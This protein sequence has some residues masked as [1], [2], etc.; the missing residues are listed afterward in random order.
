MKRTATIII[1]LLVLVSSAACGRKTADTSAAPAPIPAAA[2]SAPETEAVRSE[3]WKTLS[4]YFDSA[5]FTDIAGDWDWRGGP[6]YTQTPGP[7]KVR[8]ISLCLGM[9]YA[10]ADKAMNGALERGGMRWVDFDGEPFTCVF[11]TDPDGGS[12]ACDGLRI[13]FRLEKPREMSEDTVFASLESTGKVSKISVSRYYD[14]DTDLPYAERFWFDGLD[15]MGVTQNSGPE[16]IVALLNTPSGV[17]LEAGNI[18]MSYAFDCPDGRIRLDF[19]Y[20][21]ADRSL[22]GAHIYLPGD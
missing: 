14:M 2:P 4:K 20:C 6:E 9:T 11:D 19:G 1:C 7:V 13:V 8:N 21:E 18:A 15:F 17:Y 5:Q 12:G 10:E 3:E 16:D 22:V